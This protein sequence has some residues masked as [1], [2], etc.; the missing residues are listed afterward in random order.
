MSKKILKYE[1]PNYTTYPLFA[2]ING[3]LKANNSEI[4]LYNNFILIWAYVKRVDKYYWLDF[5]FGEIEIQEEFCPLIIQDKIIIEEEKCSRF[6]DKIKEQIMNNKYLMIPLDMYYISECWNNKREK[7]H[8]EHTPL[9][10]GYDDIKK[11][12]WIADFFKGR[13]QIIIIDIKELFKAYCANMKYHKVIL[14][15]DAF[16]ANSFEFH[17]HKYEI[18]INRIKGFVLD[19]LRSTD[20]TIDNFLNIY[21]YDRTVYGLKWFDAVIEHFKRCVRK[22]SVLDIRAVYLLYVTNNVMKDRI[23]YLAQN[24]YIRGIECIE[25]LHNDIFSI[26]KSII[27][28]QN[29]VIKYN[30][31][32]KQEIGLKI[33]NEIKKLQ[34][35]EKNIFIKFYELLINKKLTMVEKLALTNDW[36]ELKC[37]KQFASTKVRN[38]N[39][40][41]DVH[42]D[43]INNICNDLL[44]IN[45][46][47]ERIKKVIEKTYTNKFTKI[48]K[49]GF[50]YNI[51][52]YE[53]EEDIHKIDKSREI[54]RIYYLNE[55]NQ[56][57]G[58]KFIDDEIENLLIYEYNSKEIKRY[59]IKKD[60]NNKYEVFGIKKQIMLNKDLKCV[61]SCNIN[62]YKSVTIFKT[63]EERLV[64]SK[65]YC[66]CR[67]IIN[68]NNWLDE[69]WG[70][71]RRYLYAKNGI[72]N[73]IIEKKYNEADKVLYS[74]KWIDEELL[75]DKIHEVLLHC[76]N[77]CCGETI[78][79]HYEI[80]K[81]QIDFYIRGKIIQS[82]SILAN[83]NFI[84]DNDEKNR[85]KYIIASNIYII[86]KREN[87]V[88]VEYY[89]NKTNAR[90][91]KRYKKF[92][93]L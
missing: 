93:D 82:I 29:M 85:I 21:N 81:N 1:I 27:K 43:Y 23:E 84:I 48:E 65:K 2:A 3:I 77:M 90:E 70:I 36:N 51:F 56:V 6:F 60:I 16:F 44:L 58:I 35:E 52:P 10:F 20:T 72:L 49:G 5:K 86:K 78:N 19:F 34:D 50:L 83:N 14:G 12:I 87:K 17:E 45:N 64:E 75:R 18:D 39:S 28:V 41:Y 22:R 79:C 32:L 88:K 67:E 7:I 25:T 40:L 42:I 89:I 37:S 61:Y 54:K 91:I 66:I 53:I 38:T 63:V 69:T 73:Q 71:K 68:S 47:P 24:K 11:K 26:I 92:L 80:E 46:K 57:I 8:T 62:Y 55:I 33:L 76:L 31:V 74:R 4:W 30:L 59:W 15:E 9:I 13:Y